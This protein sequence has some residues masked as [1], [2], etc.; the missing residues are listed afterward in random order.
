MGPGIKRNIPL[1]A[2]F[3]I[4]QEAQ[5]PLLESLFEGFT[6]WYPRAGAERP[7]LGRA[8]ASSLARRDEW[9]SDQT[10]RGLFL[11]HKPLRQSSIGEDRSHS[12]P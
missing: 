9:I 8:L 1:V 4:C 2:V 5:E 11:F 12:D 3:E 6:E 7:S 10:G